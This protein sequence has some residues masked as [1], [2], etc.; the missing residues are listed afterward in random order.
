ME[1]GP[2]IKPVV[3][4]D[5]ANHLFIS[6]AGEDAEFVQWLTLVLTRDGYKVWCD[7]VKLLGGE[8]YPSDIGDAI[9][10]R[11][12]RFL[13]VM[14]HSS[15]DKPN[16]VKERT[17]ALN[18]GRERKIDFLIPLNL[19][20]LS[21]TQIPWM[22]SDL[23]Y[24]P[25]HRSWAEGFG[26]LKK[27]L[28]S[29]NCPRPLKNGTEIVASLHRESDAISEGEERLFSNILKMHKV[30]RIVR[31]FSTDSKVTYSATKQL[32]SIWPCYHKDNQTLLSFHTPG[33]S[34]IDD[35]AL[36]FNGEEDWMAQSTV[37]GIPST[38][39]A[40][41]LMERSLYAKCQD[42]GLVPA[43]YRE[44][45][46]Y[47]PKG[48]IEGDVLRFNDARGKS[49]WVNTTGIR[50]SRRNGEVVQF[51]FDLGVKF[52]VRHL[53]E[54][55]FCAQ[56]F[57]DVHIRG[58]DGEEL[59]TRARFSKSRGILKGW[60]NRHLLNR[61]LAIIAYLSENSNFISYGS[62]D[63]QIQFSAEPMATRCNRRIVTDGDDTKE[64][65]CLEADSSEIIEEEDME[66]ESED[67]DQD[68]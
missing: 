9:M 52:Q 35:L 66:S 13:A 65:A 19:D 40:K 57:V 12:Y 8:S 17:L 34:V 3:D 1:V 4:A 59:S 2:G 21:P 38:D 46:I 64:S 55:G 28:E 10:N 68:E 27:K 39:V 6:Y 31:R 54:V 11:S 33:G 15:L 47:F 53:P 7:A 50:S 51:P 36:K 43:K 37:F 45:L 67:A 26:R 49:T 61:Q 62:S 24:I 29:V 23:T 22:V 63:E 56:I 60:H 5:Q 41:H 16:P 20:G 25:F 14:S 42:K 48:L 30:P 32:A 18:I 44:D 58:S